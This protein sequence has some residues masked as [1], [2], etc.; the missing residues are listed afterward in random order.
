LIPGS[1]SRAP[2]RH[3]NRLLLLYIPPNREGMERYV[4]IQKKR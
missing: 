1:D 2:H 4:E 3:A